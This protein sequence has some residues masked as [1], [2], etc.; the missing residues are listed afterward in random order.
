[1][2]AAVGQFFKN[3]LDETNWHIAR[4]RDIGR[5]QYAAGVGVLPV[6]GNGAI[7]NANQ[8][9]A[10]AT[11]PWPGSP[12]TTII[13]SLPQ[14]NSSTAAT[15]PPLETPGTSPPSPSAP[16]ES[17]AQSS[18]QP[19]APAATI[20][21]VPVSQSP[22]RVPPTAPLP[23]TTTVPPAVTI[24]N[25]PVSQSTPQPIPTPSP[26]PSPATDP[27][28]SQS[29]GWPTWLK[30]LVAAGLIGGGAA[31]AT[32]GPLALNWASSFFNSSPAAQQT[33]WILRPAPKAVK[34]N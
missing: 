22:D 31:G 5:L 34:G 14:D 21:N 26:V 7:Q 30:L 15:M 11:A 12:Q 28:A 2:A 10:T 32:A 16:A 13:V 27:A 20:P 8:Q 1:M 3:L 25:I 29:S 19:A 23:A 9:A 6:N 33:E 24:P 18:P 4:N 17:P